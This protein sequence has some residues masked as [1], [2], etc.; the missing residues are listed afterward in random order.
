MVL[1][2]IS[3]SRPDLGVRVYAIKA[4]AIETPMVVRTAAYIA[5][6]MMACSGVLP[7]RTIILFSSL[8]PLLS[9]GGSDW[10]D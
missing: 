5:T 10:G 7:K 3:G 8:C 9:W 4:A 6:P 1:L 2:Y